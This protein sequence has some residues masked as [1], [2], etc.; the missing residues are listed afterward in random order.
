ML[1]V[2]PIQLENIV[3]V[4]KL[5]DA[6][7]NSLGFIPKKKFEEI[8]GQ[9]R[10][11]V[12]FQND[13]IVGFVVYRHRKIDSQTTLSEICVH[14]DYRNQHIGSKLMLSLVQ[15]CEQR[16][17]EF[18]QLKCPV[19][20]AANGFYEKLGFRLHAIEEGKKRQLN[21]WRLAISHCQAESKTEIWIL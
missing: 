6:N 10:G 15:D 5:A 18:I 4:K 11:T 21:V 16:S 17:R 9:K 2:K 8:V 13:I 3:D 14:N 7:R 12:A 19:D 1:E 20:L